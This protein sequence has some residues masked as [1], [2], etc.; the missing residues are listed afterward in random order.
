MLG[1]SRCATVSAYAL[2][3]CAVPFADTAPA[4]DLVTASPY[5]A[6]SSEGRPALRRFPRSSL[7][8]VNKGWIIGRPTRLIERHPPA[9]VASVARAHTPIRRLAPAPAPDSRS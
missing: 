4:I 3:S 6:K 9:S 2:G 1:K 8:W 7:N 5:V